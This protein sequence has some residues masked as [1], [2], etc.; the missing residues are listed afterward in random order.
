MRHD[1]PI[2]SPREQIRYPFQIR[3]FLTP[4]FV[5]PLALSLPVFMR[6]TDQADLTE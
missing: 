2:C 3:A 1:R 5:H 4:F 6:D